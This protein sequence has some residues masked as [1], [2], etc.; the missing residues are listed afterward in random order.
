LK[1]AFLG[2]FVEMTAFHMWYQ[3]N[4]RQTYQEEGDETVAFGWD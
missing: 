1:D 3:P 2:G 4:S